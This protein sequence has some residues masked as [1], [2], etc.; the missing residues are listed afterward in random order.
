MIFVN[1]Q[2]MH[3]QSTTKGLGL[4]HVGLSVFRSSGSVDRDVCLCGGVV[5]TPTTSA[6]GIGRC[7]A[8]VG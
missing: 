5:A 3:W 2:E 7:K 6:F 1:R 4:D 8:N